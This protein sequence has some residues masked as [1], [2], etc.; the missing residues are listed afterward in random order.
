M[1]FYPHRRPCGD[2]QSELFL[3]PIWTGELRP[4]RA[5]VRFCIR[6]TRPSV[7]GRGPARCASFRG[8]RCYT[9]SSLSR[10][11]LL[12]SCEG[13]VPYLRAGASALGT[14]GSSSSS[15]R[16]C[17]YEVRTVLYSQDARQA[18]AVVLPTLRGSFSG[19]QSPSRVGAST[20]ACRRATIIKSGLPRATLSYTCTRRR[21]Q[22]TT[23]LRLPILYF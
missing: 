8:I 20:L 22:S 23:P 15:S 4:S 10:P 12:L 1:S 6:Q 2:T 21:I 14:L 3:R 11:S 19:M 16:W 9:C 17:E 18:V 5:P 13:A 7:C